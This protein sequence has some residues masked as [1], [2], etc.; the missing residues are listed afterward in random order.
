[1]K[2]AWLK[3]M[4]TV[5]LLVGVAGCMPRVIAPRPDFSAPLV[6]AP[7]VALPPLA[8]SPTAPVAPAAPGTAARADSPG[9][10]AKLPQSIRAT[11]V[12]DPG[13]GGKDPGSQISTV[14]EKN[15]NLA[16]ARLVA[17]KL[18]QR[19]VSVLMTR[20]SDVFIELPDRAAAGRRADVFVSIHADSNPSSAKVGHSVIYPRTSE[21]RSVLLGR[22]I[23]QYL[24]SAGSPK[25]ILRA[26][27]RGLLVLR[28]AQCPAV[29]VEVGYLSNR[30]EAARLAS[31]AYQERLATGVAN[32]ILDYL[33]RRK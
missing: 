32:G 7:I 17:R 19:G 14:N 30:A 13:H 3:R 29:L 1:M 6:R 5:L 12:I 8:P 18:S 26:D 28:Q 16:V 21:P 9:A 22:L 27:N 2:L 15:I 24:V 23:D 11:V 4:W 10:I 20:N 25:Y 33:S 31:A